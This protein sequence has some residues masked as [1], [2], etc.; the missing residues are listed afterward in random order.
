MKCVQEFAFNIKINHLNVH[1][2]R[3][4]RTHIKKL[5]LHFRNFVILFMTNM[6]KGIDTSYNQSRI[7]I[8]ILYFLL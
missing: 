1:Q 7:S 8:T 2:L 3:K 4:E 5:L 6:Q